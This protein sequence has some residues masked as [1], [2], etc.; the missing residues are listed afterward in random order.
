MKT[1]TPSLDDKILA[2]VHKG[3][4]LE[5]AARQVLDG[6]TQDTAPTDL[7]LDDEIT[8]A[9]YHGDSPTLELADKNE[10]TTLPAVELDPPTHRR[11]VALSKSR[12]QSVHQTV[13]DLVRRGLAKT[14][15]EG[16]V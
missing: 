2:L 7:S 14:I 15:K 9:M 16:G 8:T 3:V 11:V 6:D 4:P 5:Q 1:T 13:R 12:G 10:T